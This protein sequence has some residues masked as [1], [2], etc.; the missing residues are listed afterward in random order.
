MRERLN[1]ALKRAEVRMGKWLLGQGTLMLIL[2]VSSTIV[3]LMLK[4]RYA[5]ALGVLMGVLN[6]VPVIGGLFSMMLVVIVAAI[7]SWGK[8]AG[9][10]IFYAIYVQFETSYLT[11]RVMRT[12]VNLIG[13]AVLISLLMGSKLAGVVGAMIAVPTAVLAAVLIEEYLVKDDARTELEQ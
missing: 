8:V 9:A 10:L 2:G 3:F 4:I 6:I 12:S 1:G 13:L 11:P 7:D 5:Y